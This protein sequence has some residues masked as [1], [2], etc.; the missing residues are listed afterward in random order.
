MVA[1]IGLKDPDRPG[2]EIVKAV[3]QLKEGIEPSEKVK[4]DLKSYA[5]EH[6]SKYENPRLWEFRETLPLTTV[7]KILK[8]ALREE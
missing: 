8:R 7:G 2:S 1:I 4:E 3:V 6:L 5:A